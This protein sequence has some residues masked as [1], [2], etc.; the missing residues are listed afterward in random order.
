MAITTPFTCED[1]VDVHAL[2]SMTEHLI[3]GGVDCLYVAGTTGE[4]QYLSENERKLVAETVVTCA[5]KRVTVYVQAGANTTGETVRLAQHAQEIGADG[6][7]CLTPSYFKLN[8]TELIEHYCSVS[9][10]LN[11]DFP[12]YLYNIPVLAGNDISPET[13]RIISEKCSNVIGIKYSIPDVRRLCKYM[14]IDGGHFSVLQGA[15]DI[16]WPSYTAG[17]DGIVTGS[18]AILPQL[19]ADLERSWRAGDVLRCRKLDPLVRR[20]VWLIDGRFSAIKAGLEYLGVCPNDKMR[21]P[22]KELNPNEKNEFILE[23]KKIAALYE[24]VI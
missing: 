21:R 1:K 3:K 15:D 23:Y 14:E 18:A 10:A 6:V 7:G 20:L 13:A 5:D 22:L 17:V 9:H 11:E 19:F 2:E 24:K 12:V 8:D 4:C 16:S